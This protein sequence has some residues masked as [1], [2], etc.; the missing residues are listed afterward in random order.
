MFLVYASCTS[1]MSPNFK[2]LELIL[3]RIEFEHMKFWSEVSVT[4]TTPPIP[5]LYRDDFVAIP[6]KG[7]LPLLL[8]TEK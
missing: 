7:N 1:H 3:S 2:I 6:T 4:T 5:L 8:R